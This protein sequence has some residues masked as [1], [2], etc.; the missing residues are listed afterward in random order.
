MPIDAEVVA[1]GEVHVEQRAAAV[2][3][4]RRRC[5]TRIVLVPSSSGML[6]T[7]PTPV[8]PGS[9][10]SRSMNVEVQPAPARTVAEAACS[11]ANWNV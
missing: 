5:G 10:R 8:T 7:T 11:G 3:R 1:A 4:H 9:A 2:G 6:L